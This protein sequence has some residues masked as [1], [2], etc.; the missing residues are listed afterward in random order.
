MR[1]ISR[2]PFLALPFLAMVI[3]SCSKEVAGEGISGAVGD[4]EYSDVGIVFTVDGT[5]APS[6]VTDLTSFYVSAYTSSG[7][8]LVSAW[9]NQSFSKTSDG[10]YTNAQAFWPASDASFRFA[11]SNVKMTGSSSGPVIRTS[12]LDTDIVCSYLASPTYGKTNTLNFRHILA[13]VGAVDITAMDGFEF[14]G[15]RLELT[16]PGTEATYNVISDSWSKAGGTA[17]TYTLKTDGTVNDIWIIP[18]T[19]NLTLSFTDAAGNS[20]CKTIS[21]SFPQGIVKKMTVSLSSGGDIAVRKTEVPISDTKWEKTDGTMNDDYI[22]FINLDGEGG[23]TEKTIGPEAAT[24][25]WNW[26]GYHYSYPIER[27]WKR[28]GTRTVYTYADGSTSSSDDWESWV[29]QTDTRKGTPGTA[30]GDDFSPAD[31]TSLNP[32]S[33]SSWFNLYNR[34]VSVNTGPQRSVVL[35]LH[36]PDCPTAVTTATI[37][38]RAGSANIEY[39]TPVV[40]ISVTG[41]VAASGCINLRPVSGTGGGANS[42][43]YTCT[44]TQRSRSIVNGVAGA[45]SAAKDVTSSAV[46]EYAKG[47][48]SSGVTWSTVTPA[49]TAAS[50]GTTLKKETPLSEYF[51]V[52]ATVNG[53]SATK[54]ARYSQQE[55]RITAL[56]LALDP[57]SVKSTGGTSRA[58]AT[59]SYTSGASQTVTPYSLSADNFSGSVTLGNPSTLTVGENTTSGSRSWTFKAIVKANFAQNALVSATATLTQN[60]KN[61]FGA[62]GDGEGSGNEGGNIK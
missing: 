49:Y 44:V 41:Y 26:G 19:Y 53:K 47:T 3:S 5:K 28:T 34:K 58:T 57:S 59:A 12:S 4:L 2:I 54:S 31:Y 42:L 51:F 8:S 56:A 61:G 1:K 15:L 14:S 43:K 52:K 20:F 10:S 60:K 27:L 25:T 46:L 55:N 32:S 17:K 45:W 35:S 23:K 48:S 9:E 21:S 29:E 13:R 50:L 24:L 11:A 16:V 7:S 40:T 22:V 36:H 37:I 38:Q 18:G 62:E 33:A 6:E 39:E 30:V